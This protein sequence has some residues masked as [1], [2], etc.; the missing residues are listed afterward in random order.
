MNSESYFL[1]RLF[2]LT[3][4]QLQQF[5]VHISLVWLTAIHEM[6]RVRREKEPKF[7]KPCFPLLTCFAKLLDDT[8][9]R[10]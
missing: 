4:R 9:T 2:L 5:F 1:I 6:S 3:L 10:M 7:Q 8:Q